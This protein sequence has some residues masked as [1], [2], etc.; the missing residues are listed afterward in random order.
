M[1]ETPIRILPFSDV[2]P[3]DQI[4]VAEMRRLAAE[5][6]PRVLPPRRPLRALIGRILSTSSTP[7]ISRERTAKA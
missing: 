6:D 4:I 7:T 2:S 3:R 5:G 1:N